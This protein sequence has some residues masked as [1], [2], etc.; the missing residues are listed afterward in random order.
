MIIRI[1]TRD[2]W[3]KA[4]QAVREPQPRDGD[5]QGDD[6]PVVVHGPDAEQEFAHRST[7][8]FSFGSQCQGC[9]FVGIRGTK[10][11]ALVLEPRGL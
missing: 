7:G 8:E 4:Y 1:E 3:R 2:D 5:W 11:T 6:D 9:A 10:P